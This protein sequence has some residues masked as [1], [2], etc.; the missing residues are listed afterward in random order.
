MQYIA[1]PG[2]TIITG[3][4]LQ[5]IVLDYSAVVP[6]GLLYLED[7]CHRNILLQQ[8]L[9]EV[10]A[11]VLGGHVGPRLDSVGGAG[12]LT[13]DVTGPILLH[14]HPATVNQ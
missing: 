10:V 12:H 1:Q 6:P 9:L 11:A 3:R 13:G 14:Y 4:V 7:D 8:V 2:K 5:S